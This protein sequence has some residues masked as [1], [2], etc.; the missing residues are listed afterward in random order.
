MPYF[1]DD[2]PFFFG[3]E[4][5]QE[6]IIAN[7]MASRLTL[8]YGASGVGKSSVL[9]AGVVHHLRQVAKQNLTERR[10]LSMLWCYS[11]HGGMIQSLSK[12][13][14]RQYWNRLKLDKSF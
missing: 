6:I 8:L 3:R 9:H 10:R 5:E 7:L 1:V 13:W 4:A 11:I 2:A 14:L 12:H